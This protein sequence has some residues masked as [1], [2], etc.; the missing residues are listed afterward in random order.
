MSSTKNALGDAL[1]ELVKEKNF[2]KI[3]IT[4]ITDRCGMN[5]KSFY[6]H[7]KDKYEL[8][9]WIFENEFLSDFSEI[10]HDKPDELFIILADYFYN[11]K[12]YY[13]KVFKVEGQNSFAD[14]FRQLIEPFAERKVKE[15]M[16]EYESDFFVTF[17]SDGIVS[18][19][20]RWITAKNCMEPIKFVN[21]IQDFTK[22]CALKRLEN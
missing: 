20:M 6:Y 4:D 22:R 8:M 14:Y 16:P 15:M 21:M 11:N 9:A 19:F 3:S 18:S 12:D 10:E 1:K 2:N 17:I 5:R 13:S 7:F